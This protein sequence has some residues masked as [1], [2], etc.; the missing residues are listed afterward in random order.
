MLIL[1]LIPSCGNMGLPRIAFIYFLEE[2]I[3]GLKL[4]GLFW[5]KFIREVHVFITKIVSWVPIVIGYL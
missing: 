2:D 4:F 5:R 1:I 3:N